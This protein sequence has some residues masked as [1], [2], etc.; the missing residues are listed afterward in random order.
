MI[1]KTFW[2]FVAIAL[3]S[4]TAHAQEAEEAVAA[5]KVTRVS[6]QMDVPDVPPPIRIARPASAP[7]P[8]TGS[9][10]KW[11]DQRDYPPAAYVAKEEGT[12]AF[13]MDVD[14]QG[15]P[16]NCIVTQSSGSESLDNATCRRAMETRFEP[17]LDKENNPVDGVYRSEMRWEIREPDWQNAIV[18]VEAT[19]SADGSVTD[20]R[21]MRLEGEKPRGF[22]EDRPCKG[23]NRRGLVYRDDQGQPVPKRLRLQVIVTVDDVEEA[24]GAKDSSLLD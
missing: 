9:R 14:A 19:I 10:I 21:V 3:M 5:S 22:D 23:L 1:G 11:P 15:A 6:T 12:T 24:S 16:S 18:D 8:I 7:R 2:P 4:G 13:Q 17:Q 20:C